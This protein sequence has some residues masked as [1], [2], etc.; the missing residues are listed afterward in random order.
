M[1][2]TR[3]VVGTENLMVDEYQ[4][5][6]NWRPVDLPLLNVNFLRTEVEDDP[7]TIDSTRDVVNVLSRYYYRDFRFQYSFSGRD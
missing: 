4:G 7:L 5:V 6:F 1:K 2:T 3:S